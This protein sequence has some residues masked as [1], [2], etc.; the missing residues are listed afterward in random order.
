MRSSRRHAGSRRSMPTRPGRWTPGPNT[1]GR[2]S[3]RS[4]VAPPRPTS[5]SLGGSVRDERKVDDAS[6][7]GAGGMFDLDVLSDPEIGVYQR[8]RVRTVE[9]D[10]ADGPAD[11]ADPLPLSPSP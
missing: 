3:T 11:L 9:R 2:P 1:C 8:D 10:R 6:R 5:G 4:T 7:V